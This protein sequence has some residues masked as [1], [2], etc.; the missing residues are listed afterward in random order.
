MA[1]GHVGGG[2]LADETDD[3]VATLAQQRSEA[4]A[5]EPRGS[6]DEDFAQRRRSTRAAAHR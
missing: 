6:G 3:L 5:D 4:A 2:S 1:S